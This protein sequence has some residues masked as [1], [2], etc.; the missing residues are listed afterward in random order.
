MDFP[1]SYLTSAQRT[2]ITLIMMLDIVLDTIG[3]WYLLQTVMICYF[4]DIFNDSSMLFWCDNGANF[5][6]NSQ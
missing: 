4:I 3:W 6:H 2:I 5:I 1:Y